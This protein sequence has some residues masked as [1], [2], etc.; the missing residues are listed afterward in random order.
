MYRPISTYNISVLDRLVNSGIDALLVLGAL[1]PP[2][3]TPLIGTSFHESE[4]ARG[5]FWDHFSLLLSCQ[6]R[7]SYIL[8]LGVVGKDKIRLT[9]KYAFVVF[10][11]S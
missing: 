1:V 2:L 9:R 5:T 8:V 3:L 11:L 10:S 6:T 7:A 4:T